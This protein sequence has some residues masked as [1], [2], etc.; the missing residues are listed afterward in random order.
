MMSP[1]TRTACTDHRKR[2]PSRGAN[3][4]RIASAAVGHVEN[5]DDLGPARPSGPET[6][7]KNRR[8]MHRWTRRSRRVRPTGTGGISGGGGV[9]LRLVGSQLSRHK[10]ADAGSADHPSDYNGSRRPLL[11]DVRRS[12]GVVGDERVAG[13][14]CT[15]C[16]DVGG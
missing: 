8:K 13:T 7:R 1:G 4:T 9:A 3:V 2:S 6:G 5:D 15:G 11:E 16:P 12:A 14:I 10:S